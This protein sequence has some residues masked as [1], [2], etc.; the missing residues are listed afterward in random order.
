MDS[1]ARPVRG[2]RLVHPGGP[3]DVEAAIRDCGVE[4]LIVVPVFIAE[5]PDFR[6]DISKHFGLRD[7]PNDPAEGMDRNV[8]PVGTHPAVTDTALDGA[9]TALDEQAIEGR[10]SGPQREN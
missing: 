5:G 9:L 6:E 8:V 1:R 2:N 7:D 10:A 3:P 4:C